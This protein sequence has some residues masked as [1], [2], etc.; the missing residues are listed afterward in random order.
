MTANEKLDVTSPSNDVE[1]NDVEMIDE[2][3][4]ED[5]DE[6]VKRED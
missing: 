4:E 1:L 2:D 5:E 6:E 3:K